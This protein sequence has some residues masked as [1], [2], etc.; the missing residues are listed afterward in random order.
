MRNRRSK[1]IRS[2]YKKIKKILEK[3]RIT[4]AEGN[5]LHKLQSFLNILVEDSVDR[6]YS[7]PRGCFPLYGEQLDANEAKKFSEK[8]KEA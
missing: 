7:D 4:L 2:L 5:R 1:K 6:F 8:Y 3:K